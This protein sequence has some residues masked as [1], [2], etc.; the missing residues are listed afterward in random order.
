MTQYEAVRLF[1]ERTVAANPGFRVTNE[2]APT[3]AEICWRLDGIP[4]AIE[5]AAA[6]VR[7]LGL[8][9]IRARLDDRFRLLTGGR[10]TALPR[11]QTLQA[12]MDWSYGLLSQPER[13][14]LH[15][16]SIFAGGWTLDAAEHVCPGDDLPPEAALDLLTQLG[17]KSLVTVEERDAGVRYGLLETVRHYAHERLVE[18]GE[19]ETMACR[20]GEYFLALSQEAGSGLEGP[21]Q[22][23]WLSRLAGEHGNLRATLAWGLEHDP[24]AAL[25]AATNL[26]AFWDVR[27]NGLEGRRWLERCLS[28]NDGASP[29]VRSRALAAIGWLAMEQG[30]YQRAGR[31]LSCAAQLARQAQDLATVALATNSLG[32]LA[33]R[34]GQAD[35]AQEHWQEAH[36]LW[37]G[38]GNHARLAG[39]L[40]NLGLLAQMRD[41]APEAD[42]LM[43]EA[44]SAARQSGASRY[45]GI[46][47][48]N[49]GPDATKRG[50]YAE[51]RELHEQGLEVARQLGDRT[52]TGRHLQGLGHLAA[53]QG[54]H[55]AA[56]GLLE[57]ALGIFREVGR[58]ESIAQVIGELGDVAFRRGDYRAAATLYGEALAAW[59]RMGS[60]QGAV[61]LLRLALVASARGDP[62]E[63]WRLCQEGLPLLPEAGSKR[64]VAE[65]L[66]DVGR[67][68]LDRC[69]TEAAQAA[70]QES[71]RLSAPDG[72]RPA[73]GE[74]VQGVA[75]T[76]LALG[77]LPRS[78]ALLAA[79]EALRRQTGSAMG[80]YDQQAH[81]RALADLRAALGDEAFRAAWDAGQAMTLDEAVTYAL[82]EA[83]DG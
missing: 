43:R 37:C 3:V 60:I 63:G 27:G 30:D 65:G 77:Q 25:Q 1:I 33:Y 32:G 51:A 54:E 66:C 42:A 61:P 35:A 7:M 2:T 8:E 82:G 18:S 19:A 17:E 47:L 67:I 22:A 4:L 64:Q 24:E 49:L 80:A 52:V 57:E 83:P 23:A 69:D 71:L 26:S 56:E 6:R 39:V 46:I 31:E 48:S 11:Q 41:S 34:Q 5:L 72:M 58:Q 78:A 44:L 76:A 45:E 73:A 14:L 28:A 21:G 75:R 79:A 12:A 16:L 55:E 9:E 50:E 70:F 10:R 74:A 62:G 40:C 68:A 13:A 81:G 38:L 53:A 15:R 20:H 36:R 29:G 59:R